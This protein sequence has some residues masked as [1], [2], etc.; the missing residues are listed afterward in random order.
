MDAGVLQEGSRQ[1]AVISCSVH[2][3]TGEGGGVNSLF[4]CL[5]VLSSSPSSNCALSKKSNY[6]LL[7]D[8]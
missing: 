1:S 3:S 2:G 6:S 5:F 4:T 7:Y 8:A